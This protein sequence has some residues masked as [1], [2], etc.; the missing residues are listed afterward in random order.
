MDFGLTLLT[1]CII[2]INEDSNLSA[3]NIRTFN[4][5]FF[6]DQLFGVIVGFRV[7]KG[8]VVQALT[9]KFSEKY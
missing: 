5:S 4:E 1:P 6:N 7:L 9:L 3:Q 2:Q 8:K